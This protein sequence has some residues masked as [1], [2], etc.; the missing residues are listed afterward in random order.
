MIPV[1][2]ANRPH[3][4]PPRVT[5]FTKTF[6]DALAEGRFITT[7]SERTGQL[8]FPPKPIAPGSWD[9]DVKWVELSGRGI[10]YSHTTIHASPAAFVDDLPYRI[11]IVDL[12]EGLRIAT[13]LIGDGEANIGGEVEIVAVRYDEHMSFAARHTS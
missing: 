3:P 12:N 4:Y 7:A 2:A 5:E 1:I 11:C 10:L 13:R 6:W 8:T 9:E